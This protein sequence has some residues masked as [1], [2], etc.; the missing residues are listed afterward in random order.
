MR[1]PATAHRW[2]TAWHIR[3]RRI[4]LRRLRALNNGRDLDGNLWYQ[5]RWTWNRIIANAR[6]HWNGAYAAE[7]YPRRDPRRRPNINRPWVSN[8]I[9]G[10]A[11][12]VTHPWVIGSW[13]RR[14]RRIV[15]NHQLRRPVRTEHWHFEI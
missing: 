5:R 3:H 7:G 6:G 9:H 8:H 14:A 12:D 1:A 2:S 15:A 4:R 11:M 13:S 10:R